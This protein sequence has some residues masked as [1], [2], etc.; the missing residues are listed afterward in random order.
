MLH[1]KGK[2]K[3]PA[4]LVKVMTRHRATKFVSINRKMH[5]TSFDGQ[6]GLSRRVM[7]QE[8]ELVDRCA[9][10]GPRTSLVLLSCS[11]PRM[12]KTSSTG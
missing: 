6:V 2:Y 7:S 12:G 1:T 8:A 11:G 10:H 3:A 9:C 5:K 4:W